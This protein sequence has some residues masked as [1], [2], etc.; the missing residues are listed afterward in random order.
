MERGS[1]TKA[2]EI[3]ADACTILEYAIG[4]RNHPGYYPRYMRRLTADLYSTS[5]SIEYELNLPLHGREWFEKANTHRAQLLEDDT[6]EKPDLETMAA[7]NGNI[8]LSQLAEGGS[9]QTS[10]AVFT[11]LVTT[12]PG[13]AYCPLSAANLSIAHRIQGNL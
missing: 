4:T 10:I 5:G 1:F 9:P 7:V 3:V 12:F 6:A 8:A 11:D 2:R 13:S